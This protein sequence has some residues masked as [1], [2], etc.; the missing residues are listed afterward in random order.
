MWVDEVFGLQIQQT[1][2]QKMQLKSYSSIETIAEHFDGNES[3]KIQFKNSHELKLK[4]ISIGF[5]G[6]KCNYRE[7]SCIRN[8]IKC[9]MLMFQ[10]KLCSSFMGTQ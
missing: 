1:I 6:N 10:L 4:K 3:E 5:R 8:S 2:R 9:S 7:I